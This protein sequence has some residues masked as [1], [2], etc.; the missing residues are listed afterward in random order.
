MHKNS[1]CLNLVL[2]LASAGAALAQ[3]PRTFLLNPQ[4][5]TEIKSAPAG[6]SDRQHIIQLATEAADKALNEGPFTVMSKGVT[7]PSGDKHDCMSQAPYF[8]P[9]PTKPNGLPYIRH[10]G[11]R[12]PE[13]RK[14]TDHDS[15]GHLGDTSRALALA[16][17]F[18]GKPAYADRAALLIRTW[19]LDPATHMNPNLEFGQGIPGINTGRGIGLIET[20]S[21]M[22]VVDAI[23]LIQGSTA[24][25]ASDQQGMQT[26]LGSF[27]HWM[28]TSSKGQDESASKNNHGTWYDLQ[29]SDYA[30]FLGD[31]E[32]AIAT[33]RQAQTKRTARQVEPDGRQPL[34]LV[35]TKAFSYSEGN[36]NGLMQLAELGSEVGVDLWDYRAPNDGSIRGALNYLIPFALG[37]KPWPDQQIEGFHG[38]ALAHDIEMAALEYR[39]PAYTAA[40]QQLAHDHDDLNTAIYHFALSHAK[41]TPHAG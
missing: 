36:L 15:L 33:M 3:E 6:D 38:E 21:F 23:G 27:V 9:D 12:N 35:R 14:I 37:Q 24:W 17:F 13:I 34:E 10:D 25:T 22:Q 18:T 4:V 26:W 7:P 31:R 5:L 29:L 28:R 2:L 19:F 32:L 40:A 11:R 8:W 1:L 39:D 20:R 41:P 16:Y 30:L